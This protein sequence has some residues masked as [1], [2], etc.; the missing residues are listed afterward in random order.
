MALW[1]VFKC[2]HSRLHVQ[3]TSLGSSCLTFGCGK[4]SPTRDDRTK[5]NKEYFPWI[6]IFLCLCSFITY[7]ASWNV[8]KK[9]CF[10][11]K[12]ELYEDRPLTKYVQRILPDHGKSVKREQKEEIYAWGFRSLGCDASSL[13]EIFPT[14]RRAQGPWRNMDA[15]RLKVKATR[16]FETSGATYPEMQH[17]ILEDHYPPSH[18]CKKWKIR[19]HSHVWKQKQEGKKSWKE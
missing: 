15:E 13:G 8:F 4:F 16:S 5:P 12:R 6:V 14:F 2:Y 10:I 11:H 18:C 17:H 1:A 7:N 19:K 9:E 3:N